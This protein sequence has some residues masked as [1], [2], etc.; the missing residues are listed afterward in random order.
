MAQSNEL[1]RLASSALRANPSILERIN[2]ADSKSQYKAVGQAIADSVARRANV[3]R[4]EAT[5]ALVNE[6]KSLQA[7]DEEINDDF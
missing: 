2:S 1:Q 5:W 7:L 3:T 4:H 6:A